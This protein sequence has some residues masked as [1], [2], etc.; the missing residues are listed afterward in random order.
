MRFVVYNFTL[1]Q[2]DAAHLLIWCVALIDKMWIFVNGDIIIVGCDRCWT[3][4]GCCW[5]VWGWW[6]RWRRPDVRCLFVVVRS[7]PAPILPSPCQ[8]I[9]VVVF[10]LS[11]FWHGFLLGCCICGSVSLLGERVS[12]ALFSLSS[13]RW[14]F[15]KSGN[16][17]GG[18][19]SRFADVD[20]VICVDIQSRERNNSNLKTK[21]WR[22]V[23]G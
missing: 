12:H 8:L 18:I 13:C 17:N 15:W 22:Q 9:M 5:R 21:R 16:F 19:K 14:S 23:G 3:G 2:F 4:G 1:I 10:V 11:W 6:H 7:A 20:G